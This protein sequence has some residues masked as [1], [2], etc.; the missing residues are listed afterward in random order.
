M[1]GIGGEGV[2]AIHLESGENIIVDYVGR[3]SKEASTDMYTLSDDTEAGW[4]GWKK[5]VNDENRIGHKA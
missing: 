5:V 4:M 3:P 2:M 1:N